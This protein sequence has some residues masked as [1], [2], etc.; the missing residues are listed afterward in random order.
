MPWESIQVDLFGSW[1]FTSSLGTEETIRTVS[2][3]DIATCWP[4]LHTYDDKR[5]ETISRIVDREWFC[6]YPHPS[7]VIYNNGTNS[8]LNGWSYSIPTE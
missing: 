6:R 5:S 3:I 8:D 7:T 4:K 2:I 1:Y